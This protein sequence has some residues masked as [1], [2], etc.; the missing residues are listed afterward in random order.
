M[1][2]VMTTY[3]EHAT[4]LLTFSSHCTKTLSSVPPN[5]MPTSNFAT[6]IGPCGPVLGSKVFASCHMSIMIVHAGS[7]PGYNNPE[8]QGKR[9]ALLYCAHALMLRTFRIGNKFL[10]FGMPRWDNSTL[11]NPLRSLSASA[12]DEYLLQYDCIT[13]LCTGVPYKYG[14]PVVGME[15]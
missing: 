3:T 6:N 12:V 7:N 11:L 5:V 10:V 9:W 13:S 14:K 4:A 2:S 8:K 1:Y 15:P